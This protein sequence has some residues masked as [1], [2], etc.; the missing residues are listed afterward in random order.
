MKKILLFAFTLISI[1]KVNA[2]SQCGTDEFDAFLKRTNPTYAA[3]RQKMEEQIYSILKNKQQN[4]NARLGANDCQPSGVFTIPVVV[5]VIH[6]GESIGTGT[7]ISDAQIQGAIQGMN[8]RWRR[9]QGDGVDLEIQFALAVR[10]T[11]NNTTNGITRYDGRVFPNYTTN[12]VYSAGAP[13]LLLLV[14]WIALLE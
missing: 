3:E 4:P 5:H 9:V 2:Q 6:K 11:N 7:N 8:E 13:A 1:F 10:D 14:L 12:G